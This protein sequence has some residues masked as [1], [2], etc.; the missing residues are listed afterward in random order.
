MTPD[1]EREL[2]RLRERAYGPGGDIRRDVV[3]LGRLRELEDRRSG[4]EH[5]TLSRRATGETLARPGNAITTTAASL[6]PPRTPGTAEGRFRALSGR[7]RVLFALTILVAIALGIAGGIAL[8]S[9]HG[10][11]SPGAPASQ[12]VAQLSVDASYK[13][14]AAFRGGAAGSATRTPS[15]EGFAEFHGLRVVLI[16]ANGFSPDGGDCLLVYPSE[17]LTS[18]SATKYTGPQWNG[19]AAGPFPATAQL[20]VTDALSAETRS[21]FPG[22]SLRFVY[23][24]PGHKVDVFAAK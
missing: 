1:E 21:A 9:R 11:S 23:D 17:Y 8:G 4:A 7:R 13:I 3:A 16:P 14:P 6:E 5:E 18:T 19:C 12:E 2:D 24:K 15:A 20:V 22:E 10:R